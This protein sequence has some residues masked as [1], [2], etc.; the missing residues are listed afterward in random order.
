MSLLDRSAKGT[1]DSG[2]KMMKSG[3]M[4]LVGVVDDDDDEDDDEGGYWA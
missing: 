1:I 2:S 3:G 4:H